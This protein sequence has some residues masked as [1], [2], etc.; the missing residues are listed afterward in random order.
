MIA[1]KISNLRLFTKQ[2]FLENCFDSFLVSE[3]TITTYNT[4]HI[5]GTRK[6]EFFT[7]EEW[8]TLHSELFSTWSQLRPI[9]FS[10][11]KGKKLP[12]SFKIIFRL[13]QTDMS[14]LFSDRS[15]PAE[16]DGL[17]LNIIYKNDELTCVSGTS[18]QQF[19]MDR[20]ADTIWDQ[21]LTKFLEEIIEL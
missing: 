11:I 21:Y 3:V 7:E 2:L 9:C 15:I 10:L 1:Q 19:T 14:T 13:S 12:L 20:S 5:D 4:F 6:K 16:L 17:F 8:N 18:Y